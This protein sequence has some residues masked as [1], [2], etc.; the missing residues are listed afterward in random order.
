MKQSHNLSIAVARRRTTRHLFYNKSLYCRLGDPKKNKRKRSEDNRAMDSM[1]VS[2]V[3]G[4][5]SYVDHAN[6]R[7]DDDQPFQEWQQQQQISEDPLSPA[8]GV[9]EE[10]PKGQNQKDELVTFPLKLHDLLEK[11]DQHGL[12]HVSFFAVLTTVPYALYHFLVHGLIHTYRLLLNADHW[13][14]SPRYDHPSAYCFCMCGFLRAW[15][16]RVDSQSLNMHC[17]VG[18]CF[19]IH[20]KKEFT[21]YILPRWFRQTQVCPLKWI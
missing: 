18:R 14:G 16:E 17:T 3:T 10:L 8:V 2:I 6:D 19:L 7:E 4:G 12:S 11:V 21:N 1:K 20:Q 5:C 15:H 9:P 13:L